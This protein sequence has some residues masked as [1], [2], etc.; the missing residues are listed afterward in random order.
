M[1]LDRAELLRQIN[2]LINRILLSIL[3]GGSPRG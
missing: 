1:A 3:G 2:E